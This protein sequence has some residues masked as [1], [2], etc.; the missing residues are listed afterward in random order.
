MFVYISTSCQVE[1][2]KK[3]LYTILKDWLSRSNE[4]KIKAAAP[5]IT[6]LMC[7]LVLLH[8]VSLRL[9]ERFN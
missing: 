8:I 9:V 2:D 3:N 1:T 7:S 5:H 4:N 6:H